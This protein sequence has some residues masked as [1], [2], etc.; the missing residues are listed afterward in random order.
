MQAPNTRNS[1][2]KGSAALQPL[3]LLAL[4]AALALAGGVVLTAQAGPYAG[5]QGAGGTMM[6]MGG[7]GH[8]MGPG[9]GEM[10]GMAHAHPRRMDRIYEGLGVSA[11]QRAQIQQIWDAARTD[12][13]AQREAGRALHQQSRELFAQPTVDARQAEALRQQ[14]L[15]QHD[16]ASKR[17]LQAMLD[18]SRVLTPEQRKA[19]AER[20]AERR[21]MMEGH[22]A[23][24]KDGARPQR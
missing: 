10:G 8:G 15:A 20:M 3:R 19:M 23:E 21:T 12:L 22:R 16:Q 13:R 11:E 9:M 5:P 1:A 24:R 17:T 6:A 7:M 14:M 2:R 4:T 18:T